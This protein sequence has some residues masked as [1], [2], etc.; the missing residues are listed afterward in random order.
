MQDDW[1]L[2]DQLTIQGGLRVDYQHPYGLFV[3]PRF[4]TLYKPTAWLAVRAGGGFGY[5]A[6]TIFS[7]TTEQQAYVNV[8]PSSRPSCAPKLPEAETPT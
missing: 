8:L 7:S 6:P 1:R 4:S 5:K 2:L 3:L